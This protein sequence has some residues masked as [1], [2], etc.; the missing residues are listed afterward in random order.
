[1]IARPI[2]LLLRKRLKGK[3][4]LERLLILQS[5]RIQNDD[6]DGDMCKLVTLW[7]SQHAQLPRPSHQIV[8]RDLTV[9]LCID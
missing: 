5:G 2:Y 9:L 7:Q 3:F 4:T 6:I 1:M 8:F